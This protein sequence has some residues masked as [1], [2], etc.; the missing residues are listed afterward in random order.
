MSLEPSTITVL[1][2]GTSLPHIS[3]IMPTRSMEWI[4]N[5][6]RGCWR[7]LGPIQKDDGGGDTIIITMPITDDI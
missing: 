6:A 1:V 4:I 7:T 3:Q 5:P 2:I